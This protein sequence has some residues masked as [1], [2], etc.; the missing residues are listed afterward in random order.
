MEAAATVKWHQRTSFR[1]LRA[2]CLMCALL[3]ATNRHSGTTYVYE[4]GCVGRWAG[5]GERWVFVQQ[6][7][8]ITALPTWPYQRTSRSTDCCAYGRLLAHVASARKM[9]SGLVLDCFA[10]CRVF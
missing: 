4:R 3:E 6:Q 5:S 2:V 10:F 1:L 9:R 8:L 7:Q